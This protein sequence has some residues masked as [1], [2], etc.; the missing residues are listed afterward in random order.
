[1]C[2]MQQNHAGWFLP[3][4]WENGVIQTTK[5]EENINFTNTGKGV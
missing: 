5:Q 1:M 3:P 4:P 2:L